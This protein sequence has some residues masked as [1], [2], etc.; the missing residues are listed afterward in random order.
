MVVVDA[1][2]TLE[3]LMEKL[4]E[5]EKL[6]FPIH[7]GDEGAQVG[8]MIVTNAGGVNAVRHGIM[9]QHVKA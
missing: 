9:R 8:G 1:G 4:A 7:P 2:V 6:F 3:Q 5:N